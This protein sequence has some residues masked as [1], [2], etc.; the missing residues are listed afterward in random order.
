MASTIW[1]Y[2]LQVVDQQTVFMPAGA[3]LLDVQMQAGTP[4]VWALVPAQSNAQEAVEI[5]IHGTG[6]RFDAERYEHIGTFQMNG[7]SLVFHAF[8]YR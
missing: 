2:P 5:R 3:K 1:K 4:C 7:G 6:H 8:R